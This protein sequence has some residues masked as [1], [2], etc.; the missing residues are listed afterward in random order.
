MSYSEIKTI[1]K[2]FKHRFKYWILIEDISGVPERLTRDK[3]DGDQNWT[4]R[5]ERKKK[6]S[7]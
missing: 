6:N 1:F 4:K 2:S 7:T 3:R 5:L